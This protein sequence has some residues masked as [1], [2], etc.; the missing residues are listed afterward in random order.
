MAAYDAKL[1]IHGVKCEQSLAVIKKFHILEVIK[2]V[3]D[4]GVQAAG[5]NT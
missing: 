1:F 2:L 4:A 5:D 3:E